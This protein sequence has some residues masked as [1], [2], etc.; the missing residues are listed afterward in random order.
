MTDF[1]VLSWRV[2]EGIMEEGGDVAGR[3]TLQDTE[4]GEIHNN[5]IWFDEDGDHYFCWDTGE[6]DDE[7]ETVYGNALLEFHT[8]YVNPL[9]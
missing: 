1:K 8:E 2:F 3:I 6:L 7:G 5:D 4:T 9:D